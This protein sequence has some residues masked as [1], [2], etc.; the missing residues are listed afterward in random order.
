M[1]LSLSAVAL[2]SLT[3]T[4]TACPTKPPSDSTSKGFNLQLRLADPKKDLPTPVANTYLTSIHVGAGLALVGNTDDI[5]RARTFYVNGTDEE[6]SEKWT[7]ISDGATAPVP[8]GLSLVSE[9]TLNKYVRTAHLDAGEGSPGIFV[10]G[11][12]G[13]PELAPMNWMACDEPLKYYQDKHFNILKQRYYK[14]VPVPDECVEIKL[15]PLCTELEELPSG[16]FASHEHARE[17]KCNKGPKN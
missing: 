8:F 4:T 11:E 14:D 17:I 16:S 15:V 6:G 7:T 12:E 10:T 1:L 3:G 2:L 9:D 13:T 5:S